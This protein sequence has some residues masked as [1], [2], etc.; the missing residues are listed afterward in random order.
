MIFLNMVNLLA[1]LG[2]CR[3]PLFGASRL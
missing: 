1:K 3:A 2:I